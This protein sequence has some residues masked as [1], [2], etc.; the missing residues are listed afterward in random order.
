MN[1]LSVFPRYIRRRIRN[2]MLSFWNGVVGIGYSLLLPVALILGCI[3]II[4]LTAL[5]GSIIN[6]K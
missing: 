6:F 4:A 2:L 5:F 1:P 3:L